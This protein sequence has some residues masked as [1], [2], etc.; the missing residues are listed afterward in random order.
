MAVTR[1]D[2]QTF[3]E[4]M[5][6]R[7]YSQIESARL[8]IADMT[9]MNANVFYEV[10]Y[11]HAKNKKCILVTNDA[12]DIPFDLKHHKHIVYGGSIS[13]LKSKLYK[14]LIA[15]KPLILSNNK[16]L[17]VRLTGIDA[18]I[19]RDREDPLKISSYPQITS[20]LYFD[21][22][23]DD[24]EAPQ[25]IEAIYLHTG[26]S[27]AFTQDGQECPA[28]KS[29]IPGF[30]ACHLLKPPVARMQKGTWARIKVS[31]KKWAPELKPETFSFPHPLK[32]FALM[33]LVTANGT[34]DY[35]ISIACEIEDILF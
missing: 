11:A 28:N 3:T 19:T 15:L 13:N 23:N 22:S 10:G 24:T 18:D 1:I 16:P 27:W 8:I 34:F 20:N 30:G 31:G 14:E 29:E 26:R 33:R 35:S 32:G 6:I 2:E 21:I 7:I 5:L 17:S 4:T 9:G 25:D 12:S